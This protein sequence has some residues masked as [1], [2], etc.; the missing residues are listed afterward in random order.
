MKV[1]EQLDKSQWKAVCQR[2]SQDQEEVLRA[3][4]HVISSVRS[5]GNAALERFSRE[6]DWPGFTI[7]Q[8]EVGQAEQEAAKAQVDPALREAIHTAAGNIRRF[9]EAQANPTLRLETTPGVVCEQIS[10]PIEKVGLYIPGG[11]APLF[12]TILMLGIPAQVAGCKERIMCT[13]PNKDGEVHPAMLYSAEVAGIQKI[14]KLGGAQAIAGLAYG[15]ELI[16]PVD[17]IFGPGNAYVTAAKQLVSADVAID[18]PAGPSEVLVIAD[19]GCPEDFAAWDLLAQAEHGSDSQVVL[20]TFSKSKAKAILDRLSTLLKDLPR[21]SMAEASLSEGAA[22]VVN[23]KKEAAEFANYYAA[24][25]LIIATAE[26]RSYLPL[27]QNA[28][29]IFLGYHSPESVGDYASGTNHTLPTM[30]FARSYSG[31][32]LS[33]FQKKITIQELSTDGLQN[34][35]PHVSKM[36]EAEE[37][38]AHQMAVEARLKLLDSSNS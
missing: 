3:A 4:K 12:S 13:P 18:M 25:H 33:A 23:S 31:V 17:K 10:R 11:T 15:T 1:Y 5:E 30:G 27:I 35:G 20:I 36:A 7:E 24:E 21:A 16:K 2:P 37:L 38:K 6:W 29:S 8:M 19:E 28:G 26:P 9:H 32:N 22:M 14:Y 34:L